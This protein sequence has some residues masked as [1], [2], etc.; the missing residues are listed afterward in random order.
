MRWVFFASVFLTFSLV[1]SRATAGGLPLWTEEKSLDALKDGKH[2]EPCRI[3]F[4][5]DAL[6][7]CDGQ[8]IPRKAS[9]DYRYRNRT[10]TNNCNALGFFCSFFDH[11]F[12]VG[13]RSEGDPERKSFTLVFRNT[14]TAEQ[15]NQTMARWS[16]TTPEEMSR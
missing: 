14:Q 2:G 16:D 12:I 5:A 13:W 8:A 3:V 6:E 11:R 9:V 4:K 10:Q 1:S 15:F 7:L